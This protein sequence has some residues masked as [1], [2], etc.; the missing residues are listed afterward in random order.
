MLVYLRVRYAK[1]KSANVTI[2]HK[3]QNIITANISGYT[4]LV[5]NINPTTAVGLMIL[6]WF[7]SLKDSNL[8]YVEEHRWPPLSYEQAMEQ[9]QQQYLEDEGNSMEGS[10]GEQEGTEGGQRGGKKSG[11]SRRTVKL[12]A[13]RE[14]CKVM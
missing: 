6:F 10:E 2:N 5:S 7:I 12:T 13:N 3:T 1:V 11:A 8:A 14:R 4:V 9:Y